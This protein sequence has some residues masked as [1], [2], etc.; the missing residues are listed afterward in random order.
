MV[1]EPS[2][3][4]RGS[5]S[6]VGK[7][8]YSLICVLARRIGIGVYPS[9]QIYSSLYFV[10][11]TLSRFRFGFLSAPVIAFRRQ[12]LSRGS[13]LYASAPRRASRAIGAAAKSAIVE[14]A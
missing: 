14:S 1:D 6:S 9:S 12:R 3:P 5:F 4:H 13:I 2:K 11:A 8:S 10:I 7:L